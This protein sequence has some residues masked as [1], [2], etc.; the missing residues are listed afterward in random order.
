MADVL[1]GAQRKLQQISESEHGVDAN[2]P[3]GLN[4]GGD[5]GTRTHKC[6]AF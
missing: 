2:N 5:G 3:A 6:Q 4:S 1:T